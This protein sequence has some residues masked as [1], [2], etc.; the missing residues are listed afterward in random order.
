MQ[1]CLQMV[2]WT[3]RD[4]GLW[5]ITWL[6]FLELNLEQPQ[7]SF[8][9]GVVK[10]TSTLDDPDSS[11]I[12]QKNTVDFPSFNHVYKG[13]F[14]I[15]VQYPRFWITFKLTWTYHAGKDFKRD[16]GKHNHRLTILWAI[17]QKN[18]LMMYNN[19]RLRVSERL[20]NEPTEPLQH[21][22]SFKQFQWE[23]SLHKQQ[24]VNLKTWFQNAGEQA[25]WQ[26]ALHSKYSK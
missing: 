3:E 5:H 14:F 21:S 9:P 6:L 24:I 13:H 22:K 12:S 19:L 1:L 16:I 2:T 23:L 15:L 8:F 26:D 7:H 10:Q 25:S 4:P 11:I 18:G 20:Y 17:F